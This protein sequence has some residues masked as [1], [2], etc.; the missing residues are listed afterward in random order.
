MMDLPEF[1]R[2]VVKKLAK[3]RNKEQLAQ[4]KENYN[5]LRA[6]GFSPLEASRLRSASQ[7]KVNAALTT[8]QRPEVSE[9]HQRAGRGEKSQPAPSVGPY[10]YHKGRIKN[11]DYKEVSLGYTLMYT[12]RYA[13][14]MTYVVRNPS[15][16]ATERKYYTILSPVKRTKQ[17]L[18][19]EVITDCDSMD[20]AGEYDWYIIHSSVQLVEAYHNEA[21]D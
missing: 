12:D 1:S 2:K 13:Y 6:A 21:F 8:G 19:E 14:L 11:A 18:I 3:N 20:A 15:N 5:R 9:K 10:G 16:G 4:Q 17:S 7:G